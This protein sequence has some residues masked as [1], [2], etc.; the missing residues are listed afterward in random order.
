MSRTRG[1]GEGR[2]GGLQGA[3]GCCV[4]AG[5]EVGETVLY[6]GCRREREDYLYRQ[7]LARFKQEGVLTQLNVA[8]SRDQA[9]KV[10]LSSLTQLLPLPD[11]TPIK[12]R[13]ILNWKG[14]ARIG[15]A[16]VV[17][18]N[19][20]LRTGGTQPCCLRRPMA[21]RGAPSSAA[22]WSCMGWGAL[23]VGL[24]SHPGL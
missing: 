12:S 11:I 1:G 2:A 8:F 10:P 9:E 18:E 22:M 6:Y 16:V 23:G 5:K 13:S 7:E 15:Q 14:T 4:T 3:D 19:K 20:A 24:A 17:G 21:V